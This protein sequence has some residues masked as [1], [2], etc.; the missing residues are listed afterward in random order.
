MFG[1]WKFLSQR[2]KNPFLSFNF[3]SAV[4]F[5]KRTPLAAGIAKFFLKDDIDF[6]AG[7]RVAAQAKGFRRDDGCLNRQFFKL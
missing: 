1:N 2:V 3:R 7:L 6:K 5:L 4:Y